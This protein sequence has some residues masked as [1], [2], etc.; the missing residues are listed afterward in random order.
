MI[1]LMIVDDEQTT[2][3]SL[4][5]YVPWTDWGISEVRTAEHGFA[6][7][8]L[9]EHFK[10]SILLT[11]IRMSKMDGIELARKIRD[12]FPDCKIVFLSGFSDKDYLKSAIQLQAVDYLDKPVN[13]AQLKQLFVPLITKMLEEA[14]QKG[15]VAFRGEE[16]VI[17]LI[18][19][20]E[21]LANWLDKVDGHGLQLTG[22]GA[23][24][25]YAGL[26]NWFPS[27]IEH[28]KTLIKNRMLNLLNKGFEGR[29]INYIAGFVSD[30][31]IAIVANEPFPRHANRKEFAARL[32]EEMQG[33]APGS[34]SLSVGCSSPSGRTD[35]FSELYKMALGAAERQFYGGVNRI[36]FPSSTASG[37]YE[38]NKSEYMHFKKKLRSESPEKVIEYI[39]QQTKAIGKIGDPDTNKIRNLYFNYLRILF[40]VTM[41]WDVADPGDDHETPYLW[42]EIDTRITLTDLA[43]FLLTNIEM[44]MRK[45]PDKQEGIDKI[46]EIK[47]YIERHYASNQLSIQTIADHSFLSQTYLCAFFKR[48]TGITLGEYITMLR[49][50]K[51]KEL[52]GDR[53]KKLYEITTEIGLTDTSYF[54]TLFKKYTGYAPSEYRTKVLV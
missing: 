53:N 26:I 23:Y 35:E 42:R 12:R 2:R 25:V 47:S 50:E 43:Q 30:N 29:E 51:A 10:P 52:L 31:G 15:N 36:Y 41:Q 11:D 22:E 5:D 28:E 38:I 6:A 32:L 8:S 13:I 40:E 24:L 48:S 37:K 21:N 18:C 14:H 9:A 34:L 20:N 45:S 49:I 44:A 19:K 33:V 4:M 54:S 7:L 16:I 1:N 39:N 46:N 17:D 3:E 27:V